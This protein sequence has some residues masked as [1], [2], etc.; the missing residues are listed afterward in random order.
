MLKL[1][2]RIV[3]A[4]LSALGVLILVLSF[5]FARFF[6]WDFDVL[7]MQINPTVVGQPLC[8]GGIDMDNQVS[9]GSQLGSLKIN[10][11][12]ENLFRMNCANCHTIHSEVVVGPGLRGVTERRSKEW[13]YAFVHNSSKMVLNKDKEAIEI[14]NNFNQQQMPAFQNL[15]NA[16]I[17]SILD[18]IN[19]PQIISISN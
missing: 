4:M 8:G 2:V 9:E 13:I 16:E 11:T 5:L 7:G 17:D 19:Q 3:L 12:G 6:I 18:Y 1:K 10:Q 14:F 15:S